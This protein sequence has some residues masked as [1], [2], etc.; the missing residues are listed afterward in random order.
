MGTESR[1]GVDLVSESLKVLKSGMSMSQRSG[2]VGQ[3][4]RAVI[5]VFLL[6]LC[7]FA[8]GLGQDPK[9]ISPEIVFLNGE[10]A[11]DCIRLPIEFGNIGGDLM[12][13]TGSDHSLI[14]SEYEEFCIGTPLEVTSNDSLQINESLRTYREFPFTFR[15]ELKHLR[16][17]GIVELKA[18]QEAIGGPLVGIAGYSFLEREGLCL[19]Y[20]ASKER[21]FLSKGEESSFEKCHGLITNSNN[22]PVTTS[23]EID[24]FSNLS[25]FLIDT[26]FNGTLS[27]S[28]REYNQLKSK[29]KL[30][31]ERGTSRISLFGGARTRRA[32]LTQV[33]VFGAE[34]KNVPII[35]TNGD[36]NKIGLAL[37]RRFD[38]LLNTKTKKL[39]TTLSELDLGRFLIDLSG[40]SLMQSG[41]KILVRSVDTQ[42]CP[43]ASQLQ[44]NDILTGINGEVVSS[45]AEARQILSTYSLSPIRLT[46]VRN[47]KKKFIDVSLSSP[48][49]L[50]L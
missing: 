41:T 17:T 9:V 34:F 49:S 42:T 25:S 32:V 14:D 43:S 27:I 40:I 15:G 4:I 16:P 47:R 22:R 48:E 10:V 37:L 38:F 2:H 44:Q 29:G 5:I 6:S 26:G 7:D 13:D 28:K 18:I 33:R 50:G 11:T 21:F 3:A 39:Y 19:G 23:V 45:L 46:I 36:E 8:S 12:I 20:N 1:V 31:H 30:S 24:S 35:E